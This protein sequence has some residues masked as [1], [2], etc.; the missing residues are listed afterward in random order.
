M[1]HTSNTPPASR[2]L[3]STQPPTSRILIVDDEPESGQLCKGALSTVRGYMVRYEQDPR[4]AQGLVREWQPDLVI[5]DV[6]MDALD[7][8]TLGKRLKEDER[9][10]A[11]LMFVTSRV[12]A[13]TELDG[14]E[15]AD[16]YIK[17]PYDAQVLLLRV[18][19]VLQRRQQA[20]GS[21]QIERSAS[22]SRPT[23]D[24][25][26]NTVHVPHGRDA[27][28]TQVELELLLALLEGNGKPVPYKTLLA[29]WEPADE[30]GVQAHASV[31]TST[32]RYAIIHTNVS[33]LRNKIELNPKQ[34]ELIV[35]VPR[36]GYCYVLRR[37][38]P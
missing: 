7:G 8:I 3:S 17:K 37:D 21:A 22:S 24:P 28:L 9:C 12:E 38:Q 35:N 20:N 26:S 6:M 13:E 16:E 27:K 31:D 1:T 23:I 14:L 5:L 32:K 11:N 33:R 30:G 18:K 19:K 15:F 4:R 10:H 29:Q 34:P 25:V 2:A 36:F